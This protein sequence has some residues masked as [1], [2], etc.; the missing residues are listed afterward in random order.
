[1]LSRFLMA[2]VLALRTRSSGD[3][4]VANLLKNDERRFM[5]SIGSMASL[6]T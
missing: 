5:A 6:D 4:R 3:C 1:M 2:V